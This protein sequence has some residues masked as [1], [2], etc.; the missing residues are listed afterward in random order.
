MGSNPTSPIFVLDNR[1]MNPRE[2]ER[3]LQEA[4]L[5]ITSADRLRSLAKIDD[6][7]LERAIASNPNTPTEVLLKLSG[8]D[9]PEYTTYQTEKINK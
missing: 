8:N 4:R 2:L 6:F 3:L 9:N 1:S 5:E 7:E